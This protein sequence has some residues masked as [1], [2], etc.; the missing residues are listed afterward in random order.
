MELGIGHLEVDWSL[1]DKEEL[2]ECVEVVHLFPYSVS[3]IFESAL[4]SIEERN[5]NR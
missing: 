1:I 4:V 2:D 5:K 3:H